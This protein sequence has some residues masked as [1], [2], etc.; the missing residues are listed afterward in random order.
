MVSDLRTSSRL[1]QYRAS[2]R[3]FVC[4]RYPMSRCPRERWC[5]LIFCAIQNISPIH[6]SCRSFISPV[7]IA[8]SLGGMT[9]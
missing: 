7:Y 3:P 4:R 1:V 8:I 5:A 9:T 6:V 2:S